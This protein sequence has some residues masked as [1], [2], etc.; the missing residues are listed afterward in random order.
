[1]CFRKGMVFL[2][3][4]TQRLKHLNSFSKFFW[5]IIPFHMHIVSKLLSKIT[6]RYILLEHTTPVFK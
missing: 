5:K 1:M 6:L 4:Y 2:G 3:K